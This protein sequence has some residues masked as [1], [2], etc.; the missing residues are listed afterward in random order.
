MTN[1]YPVFIQNL[2]ISFHFTCTILLYGYLKVRELF[3]LQTV[4]T[5]IRLLPK[6]QPDLGLHCFLKWLS[7]SFKRYGIFCKSQHI[8]ISRSALT[9]N[10]GNFQVFKDGSCWN[11]YL[12]RHM[13]K[14]AFQNSGYSD[15]YKLFSTRCRFVSLY[16]YEIDFLLALFQESQA[17]NI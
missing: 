17:R 6:E 11:T 5:Q 3:F 10:L 8:T 4:Q 9:A 7:E 14:R 12:F 2:W 13:S 15:G 16:C 1:W